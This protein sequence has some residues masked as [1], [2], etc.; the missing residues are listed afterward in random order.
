[1]HLQKR[2]SD[3][4]LGMFTEFVEFS[5]YSYSNAGTKG[6]LISSA[7][8]TLSAI[9]IYSLSQMVHSHKPLI[10]VFRDNLCITVVI[11]V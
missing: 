7:S 2:K 5:E 1:M 3:N 11:K 6:S 4:H 9:F 8:H 10:K